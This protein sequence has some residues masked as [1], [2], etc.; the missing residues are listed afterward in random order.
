MAKL[1]EK[2]QLIDALKGEEKIYSQMIYTMG[3]QR[4]VKATSKEEAIS[5]FQNDHID[6]IADDENVDCD[7][8]SEVVETD[9]EVTELYGE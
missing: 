5:K 7:D 6:V 4:L 9:M 1:A 3:F 2:Q 8:H